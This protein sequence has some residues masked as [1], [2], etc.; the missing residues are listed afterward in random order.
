[1]MIDPVSLALGLLVG[2]IL[3]AVFFAAL[4]GT[5]RLVPH[6]RWPGLVVLGSL[7]VR[8]GLALIVLWWVARSWDWPAVL[9]A[10]LGFLGARLLAT[11]LWG[12][13]RPSACEGVAPHLDPP[14]G[15]N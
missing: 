4:W 13:S 8:F 11:R 6:V 9:A 10:L 12:T 1:M 2:A 14:D 3:G 15:G 7:L 5:V